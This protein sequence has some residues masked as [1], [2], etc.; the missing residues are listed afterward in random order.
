MENTKTPITE[1]FD[2]LLDSASD[3]DR[4][5]LET[6]LD[7]VDQTSCEFS[8]SDRIIKSVRESGHHQFAHYLDLLAAGYYRIQLSPEIKFAFGL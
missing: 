3:A 4:D 2:R 7:A 8:E 5:F 1:I 6:A